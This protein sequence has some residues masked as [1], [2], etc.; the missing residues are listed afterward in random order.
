[1]E[2]EFE[3]QIMMYCDLTPAHFV[4]VCQAAEGGLGRDMHGSTRK[5]LADLIGEDGRLTT[6]GQEVYKRA[7]RLLSVGPEPAVISEEVLDR[8]EARSTMSLASKAR[9]A[10]GQ[11]F[12]S[13]DLKLMIML[14]KRP[15]MGIRH[16]RIIFGGMDSMMERGIITQAEWRGDPVYL[17]ESSRQLLIHLAGE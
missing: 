4:L 14:A 6:H 2:K 7:D 17:T 15:G 9:K 3:D 5:A 1:M 10:T 13:A 11:Y 8:L 12:N 16:L